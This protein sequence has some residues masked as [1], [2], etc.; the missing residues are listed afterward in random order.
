MT[1][2]R[3]GHLEKLQELLKRFPVVAIIGARQVG[4][5]TLAHELVRRWRGATT[6]FDLEDPA[7]RSRLSDPVLALEPL[8]GL[9]VLDEVQHQPELFPLLRVLADRPRRAA[10]FLVLGS[11]SPGLLRQS[12]ESLAGRIAY[13]ELG[14]FALQEV[15]SQ[16]LERLWVRGGFPLAFLA[17]SSGDSA[18]WRRRFIRTFLERDLPQL[19]ITIATAT[20]DRFWRMLA[21]YHGQV[22]NSSEFARSFG[23]ADTTVRRYLDVLTSTFMVRQLPPWSAKVA[24]RQVKSPKV[25]LSDSGILH[26]LLNLE[27]KRDIEAHPKLGASWEGFVLSNLCSHLGAR[28][29][30]CFFWA[31]HAGAELDLLVVR[32]RTRF[33]FEFKRT[34]A[35]R[36]TASMRT[37]Q[38]DL[39]L[40]RLDVVHAGKE[41]FPL[42]A[43]IRAVAI[44]QLLEAIEPL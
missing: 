8:R 30:E 1:I 21:H 36:V 5:T 11:A 31:T 27:S 26:A 9:V 14:G 4:K 22:W 42:V 41:T 33:G 38:H 43:G 35:P 16:H 15:G 18:D 37:A 17:R 23:V 39:H 40:S 32:G 13:H 20:L 12:S 3:S 2:P 28:A 29:E 6:F 34:A 24:K 19:G 7:D 44:G 25:Y 10:R